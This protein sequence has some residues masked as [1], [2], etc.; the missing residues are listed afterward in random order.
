MKGDQLF[1]ELHVKFT[2]V[3]AAFYIHLVQ[4]GT[5]TQVIT[6]STLLKY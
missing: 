4:R 1:K 5:T 3:P 2:A 6:S